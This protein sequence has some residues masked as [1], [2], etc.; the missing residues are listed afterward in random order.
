MKNKI[1]SFLITCIIIG[2]LAYVQLPVLRLD[3]TSLYIT[4]ILFLLIFGA[5]T[6]NK[7]QLWMLTNTSKVSFGIAALLGIYLI[8]VPFITSATFF[9]AKAYRNLIGSVQESEFTKDVSPVNV[10][11]IRLVDEQT[12]IRLGDK[13]LGEVPGLGSIAQLGKFHI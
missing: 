4:L 3:F 12:A 11:D 2:A 5:L 9:H 1:I 7:K 6:A 10:E 13:K 8:I